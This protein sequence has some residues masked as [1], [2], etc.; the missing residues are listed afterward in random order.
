MK[1][2][3]LEFRNFR[4][5]G[6]GYIELNPMQKCNIF[7]GRNNSGK[8][9]ILRVYQK[10][11]ETLSAPNWPSGMQEIDR[12]G[13]STNSLFSFKLCFQSDE[14]DNKQQN[15]LVQ[16]MNNKDFFFEFEEISGQNRVHITRYTLSM[17]DDFTS[18]NNIL[19]KIFSH[20]WSQPVNQEAIRQEFL[21]FAGSFFF[22][23]ILSVSL[24]DQFI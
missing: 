11:Q 8:S 12:Y 20:N 13:R 15:E 4:N 19:N 16:L 9:N 23:I 22:K 24:L 6:D 10:I 7:V 5:F 21:K 3:G 14:N 1:F 17:I 2:I 18:A